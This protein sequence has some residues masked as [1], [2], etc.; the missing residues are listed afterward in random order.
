MG[1]SSEYTLLVEKRPILKHA[2][3][4]QVDRQF[5]ARIDGARLRHVVEQALVSEGLS[6]KAEVSLVITDDTTVERLNRQY[7]SEP[8]T[9]DVLSFALSESAE[10]F[11]LPP[12]GVRHLGEVVVSYSQAERQAQEQ[13]HPTERELALLVCHGVLHLLGYDHDNAGAEVK[14]KA[15][16]AQ[17]LAVVIEGQ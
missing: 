3:D 6:S 7:R 15:R 8:R 9:T 10:A 4:V 13:G 17:V 16:E 12:D 2:I 1:L 5:K 14:M 11:V